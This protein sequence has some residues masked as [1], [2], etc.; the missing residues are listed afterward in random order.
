[1][2]VK[3][4]F[5]FLMLIIVVSASLWAQKENKPPTRK[6]AEAADQAF[7]SNMYS[8]ALKAYRKAYRKEKDKEEKNRITFQMAECYRLM[9]NL[10]MAEPTYRRLVF[11]KYEQKQ[12][13]ILR[14]LGDIQRINGK[15]AQA[16]EFYEK[17]LQLVPNDELARNRLAGLDLTEFLLAHPTRHIIENE[18]L[19]NSRDDDFAAALS[20]T[21]YN[22]VVFTTNRK[23]VNGKGKD[24]WTTKNFTDL[25][26]AKKDAKGKWSQPVNPDEEGI[27][28]TPGN[29]GT[30]F[31][32]SRM[33]AM[34][35]TRCAA[36][37]KRKNTCKI[38]VARRA[39]K[40]FSEPV[41]VEIQADSNYALGHPTLSSD[42]LTIIFASDLPNGKGGHDL[43]YATRETKSGK[44]GRPRNL[45]DSVNTVGDELFPFL[46]FDTVLYF[47]SDG[48]PGLGGL[49][50]FKSYLRT[51]REGKKYWSKPINMGSPVNSSADD[52]AISFHPEEEESGFF[53]SNRKG[54]K[55]GDDIY[56]FVV[57]P[58]IFTLEGI[59]KD[60]STLQPIQGALVELKVSDGRS[61]KS[62]TSERGRYTFNKNQV[63]INR[64]FEIV[65]S[66]EGYFNATGKLSTMGLE[67][68][69]DF[70]ID[71]ML[72]PIPRKPIVLPEILYDLARWELKPQYQ[73]SLQ[74]L[75]TLLEKNPNLTIELASHTDAR[76]T[77][78]RNDVLSQKRAQSVVDYLVL[79]GIDP[80][81][82]TAKGYGERVPRVL[83][84]D[85]KIN[86][87][88]FKAGTRLTE[89]FIDSL[90]TR[91]L[92]EAAHQLN[93]R[94][95]FTIT[96]TNF[97]P[98][99]KPA[100]QQPV[101]K[102]IEIV[103]TKPLNAVPYS[104]N[105]RKL[106]VIP[107][108]I[109]TYPLTFIYQPDARSNVI[110]MEAALDLLKEGIIT[111]DDFKGNPEE[112]ISEGAI[113]RGAVL[114][115]PSLRIGRK[116]IYDIDVVVE[117][118]PEAKL[119]I[120]K[121][122]LT[123]FG[124]FTINEDTREIIFE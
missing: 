16:K 100:G 1:M 77:E 55:G 35:F 47:A 26:I 115:I 46:R 103:T 80:D 53:S 107:A 19:L 87:F 97:K 51:D 116:V 122:T 62:T 66:K 42:E 67:R 49:D 85:I 32:N 21:A 44:F 91:E 69:Q 15:L 5:L 52:F 109:D 23:G 104:L 108:T 4:R 12:P 81:R 58:V 36:E 7:N 84:K 25:F 105:S 90:P 76:D 101:S 99:P 110:S 71:F 121:E 37:P 114:T 14:H 118:K 29:E 28:N 17:Y 113:K 70:K 68:S 34:Y 61:H 27:L 22:E 73:D 56:S 120:N 31:F 39:G 95:E 43:W 112:I 74:G 24:E 102:E 2:R 123:R 50:I 38:F 18:K 65:V 83:N 72:R 57:E 45:G 89:S 59:V 96:G 111:K 40:S 75:I 11:V 41:E 117:T 48:H 92:K 79:R 9:G 54:G 33:N 119:S 30:P 64:N 10:R 86:G 6:R 63:L 20:N 13:I 78:E 88:V 93:R 3:I 106:M 94:T 60:E 82:L 98:K 124:A 8:S